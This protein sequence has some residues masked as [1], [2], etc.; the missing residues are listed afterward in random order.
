VTARVAAED[1]Q[2]GLG[3]DLQHV[4]GDVPPVERRRHRLVARVEAVDLADLPGELR[5]LDLVVA[6]RSVADVVTRLVLHLPCVEQWRIAVP[7][8][9]RVEVSAI[10]RSGLHVVQERLP[11]RPCPARL[12]QLRIKK[13]A[14]ADRQHHAG[15]IDGPLVVPGHHGQQSVDLG[16]IHLVGRGLDR[17][18]VARQAHQV[19][20]GVGEQQT[21]VRP[22]SVLSLGADQPGPALVARLA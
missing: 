12:V 6:C 4:D 2:D 15:R 1:L 7:G 16:E 19:R 22:R 18:P 14:R 10:W 21:Q 3:V 8:D 11:A 13:V 20:V 9:A 17:L 5:H